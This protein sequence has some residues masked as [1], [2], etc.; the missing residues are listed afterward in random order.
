MSDEW[1]EIYAIVAKR[2]FVEITK[3]EA[4]PGKILRDPRGITRIAKQCASG[5]IDIA[6]AEFYVAQLARLAKHDVLVA[7]EI[8]HAE[9]ERFNKTHDECLF[10]AALEIDKM[11]NHALQEEKSPADI[12][13]MA[14]EINRDRVSPDGVRV[15]LR[16]AFV[17]H[18]DGIH[19]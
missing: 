14:D 1:A 12:K 2:A 16:A 6:T 15:I 8:F 7:I 9:L 19:G 18:R 11:A 17:R 13:L 5:E 10:T 3:L 4:D